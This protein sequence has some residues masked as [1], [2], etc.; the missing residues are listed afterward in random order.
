MPSPEYCCLYGRMGVANILGLD[1]S[2]GACPEV[3]AEQ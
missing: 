3:L 1:T 2:A